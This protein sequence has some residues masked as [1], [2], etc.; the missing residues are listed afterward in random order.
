MKRRSLLA[1]GAAMSVLSAF[2]LCAQQASTDN[3]EISGAFV[4]ATPAM[5]VAGAGFLTIT[6]KGEADTLLAFRT[7]ACNRPELH[8]HLNEDG[9]MKMRQVDKIDVPAGGSAVL[10]SGGL[11]LMFIDLV[12]PLV[13]GDSVDVTLVFEKAGDVAITMPVKKAGAMN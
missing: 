11:H 13:E 12:A 6:S 10:E 1:L 7:P 9:I 2:P 5:A 8:T 3:L 4:R